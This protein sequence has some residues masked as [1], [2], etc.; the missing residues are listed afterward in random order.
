MLSSIPPTN[1]VSPVIGFIKGMSTICAAR[2]PGEQKRNFVSQHSWARGH[3]VSTVG[4]DETVILEYTN[5]Q[6]AENTGL[7]QLALRT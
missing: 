6:E 5:K 4:W 7:D 2:V 1:G 3:L